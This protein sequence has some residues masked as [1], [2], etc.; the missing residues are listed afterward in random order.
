MTEKLLQA[1]DAMQIVRRCQDSVVTI[2]L[3][4]IT[5]GIRESAGKAYTYIFFDTHPNPDVKEGI[6]KG[7]EALGYRVQNLEDN[8]IKISWSK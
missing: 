8:Q 5:K 6:D 2:A 7:L 1:S 3:H 4:N